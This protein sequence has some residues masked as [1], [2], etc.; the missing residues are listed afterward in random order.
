MLLDQ[1]L[2]GLKGAY[3]W[4]KFYFDRLSVEYVLPFYHGEGKFYRKTKW[5]P[6]F[7]DTG[8]LYLKQRYFYFSAFLNI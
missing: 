3:L 5:N 2:K 8:L 7:C 1:I 4:N 6:W